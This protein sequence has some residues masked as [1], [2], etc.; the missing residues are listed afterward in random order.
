MTARSPEALRSSLDARLLL[1]AQERGQDVNRLR[2]HVTF[3]RLLRRVGPDWVLKGGYLLEVRLGAWARATRDVDLALSEA[4]SDLCEALRTALDSDPDGDHFVFRVTGERA[5]RGR[6]ADLGGPGAHLSVAAFLAG[7]P[8]ATIRVDVVARAGEIK[9]GTEQVTL[10]IV[11][12]EP[13]WPA[14][15][16]TAVDLEQ[17]AAEKLHAL[18]TMWTHPEP[19]TRVKDLLDVVLLVDATKLDMARLAERLAVV[20]LSRDGTDPPLSLPNPPAAWRADYAALAALHSVSAH[21]LD[22][23]M[24]IARTLI[25]SRPPVQEIS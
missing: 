17:H 12:A 5:H 1:L 4:T 24:D 19:S 8:F 23:A 13:G 9:G 22:A 14:V 2:R 6:A 11:V 15:T 3:Q 20:F 25:A 18:A 21:S 7:R 10:P 16:V